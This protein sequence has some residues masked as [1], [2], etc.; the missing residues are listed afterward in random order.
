MQNIISIALKK[1][2]HY[3]CYET[4]KKIFGLLLVAIAFL[5]TPSPVLA[6]CPVCT[7]AVV[8]GL[9]I[10]RALGIDD[11]VT[12]IWIGGLILSSAFWTIDWIEK[13]KFREKI[14]G[15]TCKVRCG[16]T[17]NQSLT[18]YVILAY[19][20]LVFIPLTLD[21]TISKPGNV[22]WGID[23]IVLG[24]AI[25]SIV[26]L[27]GIWIDKLIRKHRD[28]KVLFHFQK[29]ILPVS[30]LIISSLIFYFIT[31]H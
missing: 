29:V 22:F 15:L 25:G 24:T 5:L 11:I 30:M 9:G 1:E 21:H 2:L 18:F 3:H 20:L 27:K 14:H 31:K 28:G 4:M 13:S 10:S 23:K 16:M 19:Y 17:E 12:S 7:V 8:A 6:V 26:F